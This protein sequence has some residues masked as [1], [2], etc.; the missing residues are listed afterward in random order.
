M[1]VGEDVVSKEGKWRRLISKTGCKKKRHIIMA[2]GILKRQEICAFL[3]AIRT[4]NKH[5]GRSIESVYLLLIDV[6]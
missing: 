2:R 5:G 6:S 3:F 4:K 1:S